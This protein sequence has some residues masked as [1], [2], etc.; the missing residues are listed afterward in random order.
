MAPKN[1]IFIRD[2]ELSFLF[3]IWAKI[4]VKIEVKL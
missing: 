2:Y 4:L 1:Q 3:T